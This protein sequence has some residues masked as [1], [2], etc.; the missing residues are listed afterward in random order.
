MRI[1]VCLITHVA[2]WLQTQFWKAVLDRACTPAS[3]VMG[4]LA[5]LSWGDLVHLL[6]GHLAHLSWGWWW[7]RAPGWW[8]EWRAP[9]WS[10]CSWLGKYPVGCRC[11]PRTSYRP[12][13]A[14]EPQTLPVIRQQRQ[15]ISARK[16]SH[17]HNILPT[18]TLTCQVNTSKALST[19]YTHTHTHTHTCMHTHTRKAQHQRVYLLLTLCVYLSD[20]QLHRGLGSKGIL[21]SPLALSLHGRCPSRFY[22]GHHLHT[23]T[24]IVRR[25]KTRTLLPR[26]HHAHK[27]VQNKDTAAQKSPHTQVCAKQGHCCPEIT[28]CTHTH[29]HTSVC[30]TKAPP[31]RVRCIWTWAHHKFITMRHN[32]CNTSFTEAAGRLGSVLILITCTVIMSAEHRR[33]R[34]NML[35]WATQGRQPTVSLHEALLA[36]NISWRSFH[37]PPV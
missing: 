6:W 26:D 25:C 12:P 2:I 1:S 21:G 35:P 4:H 3:P 9:A 33:H 27:S 8:G 22:G 36:Q 18:A 17:L 7:P 34:G 29:T 5:H 32:L 37:L 28:T 23:H 20:R 15:F 31:S 11:D 13:A 16:T 10:Q 24:L 14:T 30:T 19:T